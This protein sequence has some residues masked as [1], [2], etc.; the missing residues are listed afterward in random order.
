LANELVSYLAA[1]RQIDPLQ[2][3]GDDLTVS[4]DDRKYEP[5]FRFLLPG[6][7]ASAGV[8]GARSRSEE[9]VDATHKG[10]QLVGKLKDLSASGVYEVHLQPLATEIERRFFAVNVPAGEGD[11]AVTHRED[12]TRQLAG[13]N[14][15]LHD[16]ADMALGNQQLAGFQMGDALL[17]TIV[18]M[19]VTEQ[20][21]A[22]FAS[23]HVSPSRGANQ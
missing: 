15:Q 4:V 18:I 2:Q 23:Y 11:L 19:L 9:S 3:V 17:A 14:F 16:A 22:Y 8:A 20:L 5:Q 10:D 21:L 13:V 1:T 12:L 7:P 6:E